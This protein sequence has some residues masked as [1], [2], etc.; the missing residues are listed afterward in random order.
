MSLLSDLSRR[1]GDAF[2]KLGLD[3]LH[4]EVVVSQ[5]PELGQFQCNG[6]LAAANAAARAPRELASEVIEAVSEPGRFAELTVAGPGFINITVTDEHLVGFVAGAADDPQLGVERA[7][8]TM[9]VVVDYGGPNV[10]KAMH[11]GHLRASIIGDS[12]RRLF[13][14]VGHRTIGDAHFGDW[15]L[16]IGQVI[17]ELR[18][19]RPELPY[20]D[21]D[22]TGPYPDEPPVSLDDL[23]ELYPAAARRSREDPDYRAEARQATVDLQGRRP[24]YVALWQHFVA[25]SRASQEDDFAAL[26]VRF[27]LWMGE[28]DV[29]DR[30]PDLIERMRHQGVTEVSDG[31]VI[32]SVD[33][34]GDAK[35]VPPLLLVTSSGAY[36]YSTT[37][38][39]TIDQRVAELGADLILYVVDHRQ[40]LHFEQVFRAA[41]RSGIAPARVGLE[42][43]GF[44]TING[45]DGKPFKTRAGGVLALGDLIDLV[46][47]AARRRLDEAE[48]AQGYSEEERLGI[49]RKVGIAALKFGDLQNHRMSNYLFDLERFTS[50]EGKTGPYLLYG[51]VRMK[52]ILRKAEGLGFAPSRLVAPTVEA[53]RSLMLVLTRMPGAVARAIEFR[54]PNHLAEYA[55]E[56]VTEFNRFYDACHILTEQDSDVRGSWLR[57]VGLTLRLLERLL[58]LL[59]IDVPDR[60]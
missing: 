34:P 17:T 7:D 35:E 31:A 54:A 18:R 30:I 4:G 60:M 45:P 10:A 12:L 58:D 55:Y 27:D 24:G 53:E 25:V 9:V 56:V 1:F 26:G 48:I 23:Q 59:G 15:G 8:P 6:A 37:D 52:S 14:F 38:L 42:H 40:A 19:R 57:L 11:V 43:I 46:T 44:G 33:E 21:P 49:A 32:V 47:E 28:S 22:S 13:A 39:A 51:A 2:E 36:L 20:F 50:F 3:R 41:H 16:Q 5:R 29:Q